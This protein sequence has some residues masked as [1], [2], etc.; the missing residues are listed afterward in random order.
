MQ[1][2]C[3]L[4]IASPLMQDDPSLLTQ[5]LPVPSQE[6]VYDDL[7]TRA[8]GAPAART[9][10]SGPLAVEDPAAVVAQRRHVPKTGLDESAP[11]F[12]SSLSIRD[13]L[14]DVLHDVDAEGTHWARGRNYRASFDRDSFS[15]FPVF[16]R[17]SPQEFPVE[18]ALESATL[19]GEPLVTNDSGVTRSGNSVTIGRGAFDEVYHLN[20]DQVEQTFVFQSL[21]G[22]GELSV[23]L[24]VKTDLVAHENDDSLYFLHP[25]FGH[26][27]Y[28]GAFVID[29]AGKREAIQRS[30]NG[31]S[32]ELTVPAAFL[33]DATFPVTI[34]PVVNAF[35]SSFGVQDDQSPDIAFAG[36]GLRYWV[37]WQEYTS[38]TNADAF[39]TRFTAAGVQEASFLVEAG[40]DHWTNPK[41]AYHYGSDRLLVVASVEQGGAGGS[42][43]IQGRLVDAAA[44]AAIGTNFTI[45]SFGF[46]KRWPDVG[47][48]NWDSTTNSH[49]CVTWAFEAAPGNHNPQYRIVDWDGTLVTSIE[50]VD[51]STDDDIHTTIS[52]SQ[53][54][55]DLFGDWWTMAWIRDTNSDGRGQVHARR[56]VWSGDPALGAGN[57][58]VDAGTQSEFPSVTSRLDNNLVAVADRPSIVA[59]SERFGSSTHPSGFQ[60]SIY[61]KVVTDGQAFA[62]NSVSYVLEDV[63]L[64]LD[65]FGVCVATDGNAFYM[66]YSEEYWGSP[67][68][69]DWDMYMLSGHLTQSTNNVALAL[70]ERHQNMSFSSFPEGQGRVASRWDGESTSA[71]DD[72]AAIWTRELGANGG[73]LFGQTLEVPTIDISTR[74]AVG[75]QFCDANPNSR[76]SIYSDDV[77]SWIWIE[78]T[79]ELTSTHTVYCVDLPVNSTGYM[80]ASKTAI[81]VNMP[82]GSLGR[83]CLGGSGRY[84]NAVQNSGTTGT[85]S[86]NVTPLNIPQPT[87]FVSALPGETWYFQ[88]WHR[89]SSGGVPVSN[90]SGAARVMFQ[91]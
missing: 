89:D 68:S 77:S 6:L 74:I 75:S 24:G 13:L 2:I 44:G 7:S 40:A 41:I 50:T 64:E 62:S 22:S 82:A 30:W 9:P 28:G 16:G 5:P 66:T 79:Q 69:G 90:F 87:G 19:G 14:T 27:A 3:L 29:G 12:R 53:G 73:G 67:G 33:A 20:L 71:S 11:E 57:F 46:P 80:L 10:L 65:Q 72:G 61:A 70:C 76:T 49:F 1:P 86:T 51:T 42:G 45:S 36:R 35:N 21:P 43:T 84:I 8:E 18:F 52:D 63:D 37:C 23:R 26:V 38:A 83:L 17:Q 78:G 56:V 47:G 34:D 60:R 39:V 59:W 81:N 32:I 58:L 15:M 55:S 48:N 54:D 31:N 25:E 4:L 88:Y 85:Y 91:P